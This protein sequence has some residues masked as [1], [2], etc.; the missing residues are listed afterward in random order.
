MGKIN[1]YLL[2]RKPRQVY[3]RTFKD[4][5]AEVEVTLSLR[6]LDIPGQAAALEQ[7]EA[8]AEVF[9]TGNKEEEIDPSPFLVGDEIIEVSKGLL[10]S[11][12]FL[13]ASQ[14]EQE[15][16]MTFSADEWVAASVTMPGVWKGA[17]AF[18]RQIQKGETDALKNGPG[19]AA[20]G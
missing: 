19:G 15:G 4:P 10:Q 7:T 11:A 6:K 3:T 9:I 8:L 17:S 12:C 13:A 14:I 18:F 5:E 20:S 16:S 1:P 2:K